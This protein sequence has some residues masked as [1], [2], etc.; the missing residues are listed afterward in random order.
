MGSKKKATKK[1]LKERR[2][3][4]N[5]WYGNVEQELNRMAAIMLADGKITKK[6]HDLIVAENHR[7]RS[8]R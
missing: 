2:Q 3:L 5:R 1:T 8:L 6:E 7:Q 4:R